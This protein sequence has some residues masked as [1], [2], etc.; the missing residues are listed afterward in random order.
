MRVFSSSELTSK[1]SSRFFKFSRPRLSGLQSK[2]PMAKMRKS[3][4]TESR[5]SRAAFCHL[6][7]IIARG[8]SRS[9]MCWLRAKRKIL[10]CLSK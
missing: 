3:E 6:S 2:I 8:Y 1:P 4:Q 5:L 7:G 9:G 10:R